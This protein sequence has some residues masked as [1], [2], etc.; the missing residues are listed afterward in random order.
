MDKIEGKLIFLLFLFKL[1]KETQKICVSDQFWLIGCGQLMSVKN[2][3]EG[4]EGVGKD[5]RHRGSALKVENSH[6]PWL[7]KPFWN[8]E[9]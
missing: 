3:F 6:N 8:D 1:L 9:S 5:R 4:R 2:A 7:G